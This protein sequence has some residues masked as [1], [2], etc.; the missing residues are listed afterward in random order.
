MLY[1]YIYIHMYV[2]ILISSCMLFHILTSHGLD[3]KRIVL[4]IIVRGTS[5]NQVLVIKPVLPTL[6]LE[7]KRTHACKCKCKCK[8]A[9]LSVC[10]F[11]C[12]CVCVCVTYTPTR[13]HTLQ[14]P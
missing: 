7:C 2:Y 1:M 9:C 14:P 3:N 11:V 8:Y 5:L 6:T 10:V 4:L 13:H 12:V